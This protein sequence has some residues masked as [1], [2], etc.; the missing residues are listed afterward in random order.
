MAID[1]VHLRTYPLI[2]LKASNLKLL[3]LKPSRRQFMYPCW[4]FAM[5]TPYPYPCAAAAHLGQELSVA[6]H[7]VKSQSQWHAAQVCEQLRHL[8]YPPA[9]PDPRCDGGSIVAS[10]RNFPGHSQS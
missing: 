5:C 3:E 4:S 9:L 2:N 6:A 7:A 8:D 10:E 1:V